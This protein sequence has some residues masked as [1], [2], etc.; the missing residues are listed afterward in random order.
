MAGVVDILLRAFGAE[1]GDRNRPSLRE[2][3]AVDPR[4]HVVAQADRLGALSKGTLRA[5]VDQREPATTL[6][7]KIS[8]TRAVGQQVDVSVMNTRLGS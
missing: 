2:I 1:D 7:E 5:R 3:I 6:A 4:R 8:G